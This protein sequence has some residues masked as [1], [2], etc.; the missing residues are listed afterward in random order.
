LAVRFPCP[1]EPCRFT[2]PVREVVCDE[3]ASCLTVRA[4][5]HA[6]VAAYLFGLGEEAEAEGFLAAAH[7]ESR[8]AESQVWMERGTGVHLFRLCSVRR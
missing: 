7:D 1:C 4:R 3:R 6:D 5:N 8:R 2:L